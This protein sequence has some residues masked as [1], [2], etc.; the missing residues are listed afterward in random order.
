LSKLTSGWH[1]EF[2]SSNVQPSQ[3]WLL[4]S[5]V[6][7]FTQLRARTMMFSAMF[8]LVEFSRTHRTRILNVTEICDEQRTYCRALLFPTQSRSEVKG[9]AAVEKFTVRDQTSVLCHGK[10]HFTPLTINCLAIL[11][12][13]TSS[14]LESQVTRIYLHRGRERPR[15]FI[16]TP[17]SL[18][19]AKHS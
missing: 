17:L 12:N 4:L 11:K 14:R 13:C 16:A 18:C 9:A 3:V 15:S 1:Q 5:R 19:L 2:R 10:F 8:E 6:D 7:A